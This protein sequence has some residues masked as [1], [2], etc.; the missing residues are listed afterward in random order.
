MGD[1]I[2]TALSQTPM[3]QT[4]GPMTYGQGYSPTPFVNLHQGY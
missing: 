2:R 3:G 4:F 1:A